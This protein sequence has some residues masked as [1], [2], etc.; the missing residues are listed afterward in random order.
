MK[1]IILVLVLLSAS[2]FWS[3]NDNKFLN[4]Q[5]TN[6]LT[7]GETFS[8]PA[9]VTTVLADLYDRMPRNEDLD[10]DGSFCYTD[11][12]FLSQPSSYSIFQFQN[13]DFNDWNVSWSGTYTYIRDLNLFKERLAASATLS[14]SDKAEFTA[15]GRFLL[16]WVY[17][18]LVKRYGGVPL[19]LSSL[20]YN[21]SGD[22]SYLQY[23]RASESQV[24]DYV[25]GQCDSIS[26]VL[27]D[28]A[29]QKS[30]VTKAA[31]LALE[32][33]AALYA[34]S[35]EKYNALRTPTVVCS[36]DNGEVGM[37]HATHTSDQY[38]TI[39]LNA[40]KQIIEGGK[41][42]LYMKK[43]T[44]LE[45]NFASLFTDKNN[46]PEV[47][48]VRDYELK[49]K[50]E[51]Y[52]VSNQPYGET[53]D[54]DGGYLNPSLNL[55]QS[56]EKTDNTFAPF[57]IGSV[58]NPMLYSDPTTLFANR[59]ARLGGTIIY[60]GSSFKGKLVD[61]WAGLKMPDGT[62][63][64]AD[65][66]NAF[67]TINGVYTQVV[68]KDGPVDLEEHTAQ[69]GFLVRKYL[70]PTIG[71]GK[72]GTRSDVWWVYFRYAEVLMIAAEASYELGDNASAAMYMN[73][74]RA[75]AGLTIPLKPSEITFDRIV[76]ENRVEFAFEDHYLW[77]MKRWRLA[78]VVWNG[79]N[80]SQV[81]NPSNIEAPS[82][83]MYGLWPYK[84]Y[85]PG[86]ADDGEFYFVQK[87]P[88][89]VTNARLFQLG[90]YYTKIGDDIIAQNPKITKNPNQ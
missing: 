66:D 84:I 15:E 37:T 63:K 83:K 60:P 10:N 88:S 71:S 3:C 11:N 18:D 82:T 34:A 56:F 69:T 47:I 74:V 70:D 26:S 8:D 46:N 77:D 33:R 2:L 64:T 43:S 27:P 53:E 39:A 5:P 35:I 89:A 76:H 32:A 21:Y 67:T 62:I 79:S 75:R 22:V 86:K 80:I 36:P 78:N 7:V 58:G 90:N 6:I 87:M 57:N 54:L 29:T 24:Y 9:T 72:R 45:D 14:T 1:N 31:A 30:R 59:D 28:D 65:I 52:T 55:A 49:F 48:F 42:S 4:V 25:I 12:A 50:T 73:Q 16:A 85:D 81:P 17:F 41:Y 13:Y 38:Y 68:G 51:G 23:P 61:I 44:D 20:S 19:V 40:A